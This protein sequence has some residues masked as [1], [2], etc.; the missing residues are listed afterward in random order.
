MHYSMEGTAS[1]KKFFGVAALALVASFCTVSAASAYTVAHPTY[2][3]NDYNRA[4]Q[5]PHVDLVKS[6]GHK[7]TLSFVNTTGYITCFEYRTDGDVS[8][9]TTEHGGNNYNLA[10]TDGLYPYLCLTAGT[11]QMTFRV[12]QF[13][14]V[15]S[16]FGAE[17]DW[18]F[19]WTRF[20]AR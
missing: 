12:G 1:M 17:R 8:Q 5:L 14:E 20:D 9:R 7:V 4:H 3:T 19:T 6:T 13:V 11:Q 10:I 16:V 18:D 15:R 2:S